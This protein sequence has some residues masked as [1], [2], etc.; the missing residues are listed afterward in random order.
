MG[1]INVS[2]LYYDNIIVCNTGEISNSI[3]A[4]LGYF[5]SYP[6]ILELQ[7]PLCLTFPSVNTGKGR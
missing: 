7:C 4:P 2:S 5:E 6:S 1:E 3:L